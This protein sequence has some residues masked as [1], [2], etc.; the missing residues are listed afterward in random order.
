MIQHHMKYLPHA[1]MVA[2]L[3]DIEAR[4][5]ISDGTYVFTQRMQV[6]QNLLC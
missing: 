4:L 6:I 3:K 2:S 1:V 5:Y